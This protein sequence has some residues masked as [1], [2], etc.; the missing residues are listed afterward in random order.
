[1]VYEVKPGDTL[2]SI[3]RRYNTKVDSI[4]AYNNLTNNVLSIGQVIQIPIAGT[5]NVYQTYSVVPGDTLYS[6]ARRYNTTIADIMAINSD[7]S[8][9]LSIGQVIK[10]PQ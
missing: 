9:I 7:L 3:A 8:S 4:K 2:Y 1:M 6:I 5:E 10:I